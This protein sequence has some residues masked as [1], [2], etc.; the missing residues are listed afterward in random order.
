[1]AARGLHEG[2]V[3]ATGQQWAEGLQGMGAWFAGQGP[4]YEAAKALESRTAA[5][6]ARQEQED[7]VLR[8]ERRKKAMAQ[9]IV[10]MRSFANQGRWDLVG[11]TAQSRLDEIARLGG[12]PRHTQPIYEAAISGDPAKQQDAL[13]EMNA[14]YDAGVAAGYIKAAP[15]AGSAY[16]GIFTAQDGRRAGLNNASGVVEYLPS[17]VGIT[18]RAPAGAE[19]AGGAKRTDIF[20]NGG[21]MQSM[22]DGSLRY[23]DPSGKQYTPDMPEWSAAVSSAAKSGIDYAGSVAGAQTTAEAEA[24]AKADLDARMENARRVYPPFLA[25]L[26]E[27]RSAFTGTG[28]GPLIGRFAGIT[29]SSQRAQAINSMMSPILKSVIRKPGEGTWTDGDQAQ[30]DRMLLQE[31][32]HTAVQEY[33]VQQMDAFVRGQLGVTGDMFQGIQ[34]PG[35]QPGTGGFKVRSVK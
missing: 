29:D 33:K 34:P 4:Q 7:I 27:A 22:G 30:L 10:T 11:Q 16:S 5:D 24:K 9:D 8:D 15:S 1:M 23:T 26:T 2:T 3:M 21:V 13:T 35:G 18:A 31:T 6:D 28:G 14:F 32:E 20:K 19:T 12:D 17:E 25:A